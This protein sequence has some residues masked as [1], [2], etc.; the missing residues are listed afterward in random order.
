MNL[1]SAFIKAVYD[2]DDSP[3]ANKD[4][5]NK[6]LHKFYTKLYTSKKGQDPDFKNWL[7]KK[8]LKTESKTKARRRITQ[9]EIMATIK[10]LANNKAIGSDSIPAEVYKLLQKDSD[11]LSAFCNTQFNKFFLNKFL[12]NFR[13]NLT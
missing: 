12:N 11:T 8:N 9:K 13:T 6:Q 3:T 10:L 4:I 7:T 5:V 1:R 2:N